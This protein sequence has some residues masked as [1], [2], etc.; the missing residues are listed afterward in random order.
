MRRLV[1]MSR[2]QTQHKQAKH[3]I[4]KHTVYRQSRYPTTPHLVLMSVYHDLFSYFVTYRTCECVVLW[5]F[6]HPT[7]S[8]DYGCTFSAEPHRL[9]MHPERNRTKP[10][11]AFSDLSRSTTTEH[12]PSGFHPSEGGVRS[13]PS[14]VFLSASVAH[15]HLHTL[16]ANAVEAKARQ[17]LV[18][19]LVRPLLIDL[20]AS[21]DVGQTV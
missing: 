13:F 1:L 5:P 18:A 12:H 10:L 2:F 19:P 20:E 6:P 14:F 8:T 17:R 16:S 7:I 15:L 21:K 4:A 3:I 11:S 9:L